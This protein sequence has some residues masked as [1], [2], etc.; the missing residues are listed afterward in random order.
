M[1]HVASLINLLV[2]L[3]LFPSFVLAH[4]YLIEEPELN[5]Q[6]S[7]EVHSSGLIFI[8]YDLNQNGVPDFFALRIVLRS[9]SSESSI[10]EMGHLYPNR[11]IFAVHYSAANFYYITEKV[12]TFYAMDL[13]EDGVWDLMY[14][15]PYN[16]SVNGNETFYDSPSGMF[17]S[18]IALFE[19]MK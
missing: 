18:Q 17:T 1:K 19:S 10:V 14:K 9:Y 16:D 12:P 11:L 15:D 2:I 8:G 7:W 5:T 4:P 6:V 13:N 3:T